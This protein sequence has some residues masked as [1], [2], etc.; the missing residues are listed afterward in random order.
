MDEKNKIILPSGTYKLSRINEDTEKSYWYSEEDYLYH[1]ICKI[2]KNMS[3][4][5]IT[6]SLEN[7]GLMSHNTLGRDVGGDLIYPTEHRVWFQRRMK[8]DFEDFNE[9]LKEGECLVLRI[10]QKKAEKLGEIKDDDQF[11][12]DEG[13][14]LV[15]YNECDLYDSGHCEFSIPPKYIEY[16]DNIDSEWKKISQPKDWKPPNNRAFKDRI[17]PVVREEMEL[18]GLDPNN[19]DDLKEYYIRDYLQIPRESKEKT[20][21]ETLVKEELL[22][23]FLDM[24]LSEFIENPPRLWVKDEINP[25]LKINLI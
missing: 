12:T 20:P 17:N 22:E 1:R 16:K 15:L 4:K 11:F 2:K 21:I 19:V 9:L 18:I 8:G 25:F 5:E 7:N 3:I 6:T 13:E 10:L 24:D 23:E 14:V